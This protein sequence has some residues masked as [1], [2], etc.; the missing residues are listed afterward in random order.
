M[1]NSNRKSIIIIIIIII[2]MNISTAPDLYAFTKDR[3]DNRTAHALQRPPRNNQSFNHTIILQYI[4]ILSQQSQLQPRFKKQQHN[5]ACTDW[6]IAA[7][8]YKKILTNHL[9]NHTHTHTHTS[10]HARTCK[11]QSGWIGL[12]MSKRRRQISGK[13]E[14]LKRNNNK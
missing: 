11:P 3:A 13:K 12:L 7:I 4:L 10:T 1:D 2:T 8:H 5:H 9:I 14:K 6:Y